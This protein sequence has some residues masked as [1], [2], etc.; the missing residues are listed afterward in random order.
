ML[1]AGFGSLGAL[2]AAIG[3][4]GPLAYTVARRSVQRELT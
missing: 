1:S 4:Y 3:L 2:L